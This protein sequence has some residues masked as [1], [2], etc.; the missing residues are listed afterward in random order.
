ME[1]VSKNCW[2]TEKIAF[3]ELLIQ[4]AMEKRSVYHIKMKL[5]P[6]AWFMSMQF[7]AVIQMINNGE[8]YQVHNQKKEKEPRTKTLR[9]I[10]LDLEK[11]LHS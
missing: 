2:K 1:K 11:S 7:Y 3:P 6:A 4:L 5:K 10:Y 8:L 9:E